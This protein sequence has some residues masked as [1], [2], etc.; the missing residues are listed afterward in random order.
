MNI[1]LYEVWEKYAN[2]IGKQDGPLMHVDEQAQYEH[3]KGFVAF[4]MEQWWAERSISS[5]IND[6]NKK[7]IDRTNDVRP[8]NK[9]NNVDL[10]NNIITKKDKNLNINSKL[11][12]HNIIINQDSLIE[13]SKKYNPKYS[14]NLTVSKN[15]QN[16]LQM[17]FS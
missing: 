6:D 15:M 10:N 3:L 9:N 17:C 1:I 7:L 14:F 5:M 8:T 13:I 4:D 2:E 11:N 12:H 16:N